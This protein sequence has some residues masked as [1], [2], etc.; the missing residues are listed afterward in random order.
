[1]VFSIQGKGFTKTLRAFLGN[2]I[3]NLMNNNCF[4]F[5]RQDF[6]AG[7]GGRSCVFGSI[8]A[9]NYS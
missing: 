5:S 4:I 2:F 1:M 3:C 9:K 7:S 6:F 8:H